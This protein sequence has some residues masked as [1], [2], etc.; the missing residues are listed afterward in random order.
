MRFLSVFFFKIWFSWNTR[1][2]FSCY[3]FQ[4]SFSALFFWQF[5]SKFHWIAACTVSL[6]HTHHSA[7][8]IQ[9]N[10]RA[11]PVHS[12]S[13]SYLTKCTEWGSSNQFTRPPP[14]RPA[15]NS[16]QFRAIPEQFRCA[17]NIQFSWWRQ[18]ISL[19]SSSSLLL[20]NASVQRNDSNSPWLMV[21]DRH[22]TLSDRLD[23]VDASL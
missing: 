20:I 11:V 16:K 19:P 18:S 23:A 7:V 9:S 6:S 1:G 2:V 15:L 14:S 3:R 8:H 4:S 21:F 12:L 5:L 13:P 10:S 17:F 22:Q